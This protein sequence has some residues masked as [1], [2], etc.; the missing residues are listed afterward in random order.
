[1]KKTILS[2][3]VLAVVGFTSCEK[4]NLNPADLTKGGMS[5]SQ[6]TSN[7]NMSLRLASTNY[8][9]NVTKD[10]V[11]SGSDGQYT[12][13]TIEYLVDGQLAATVDF[14]NG[15][16]DFSA[17]KVENGQ[18]STIELKK[19]KK[20]SKY[21]KVIVKPLVKTDD[22]KY[23][24]EGIIKYYLKDKWVATVDYGDGTCDEWAKKS[25]PGGSEDFS[26][27]DWDK[28]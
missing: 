5:F 17:T 2:A 20:E 8:T 27:N 10:L 1:M 23:I 13:G 14:G 22:C 3:A 12:E 6:E 7:E 25:Y 18:S 16:Q 28:K 9:T 26:M 11:S 24:V 19:D 15:E 4:G 21:K